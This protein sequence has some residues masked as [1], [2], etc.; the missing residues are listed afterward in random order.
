MKNFDKINKKILNI[1]QENGG[2]T[3]AELSKTVGLTPASTL[4]R[5]KKLEKSGVIRQYVALVDAEKVNR[6]LTAFVEISLG[7]HT[8][9]A[10]KEF[11]KLIL[12]IDEVLECYH[13]AGD[14]DFLLKI[15]TTDIKSYESFA[16]EK[17]AEIPNLG[18]VQTLFVLSHVKHKTN[19]TID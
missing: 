14:K 3:N 18:K 12:S 5:V 16:I 8:G 6:N 4:E 17:L 7:D 2:I 9:A 10:I 19:I 13:I 11:R 15:V 1:L